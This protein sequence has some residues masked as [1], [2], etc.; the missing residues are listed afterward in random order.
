MVTIDVSLRASAGYPKEFQF[1][2]DWYRETYQLAPSL[3]GDEVERYFW[4]KG[5]PK[6]HNLSPYFNPLFV[7]MQLRALG[8]EI[9]AKEDPRDAYLENASELDPHPLLPR[10]PTCLSA[11]HRLSK[12]SDTEWYNKSVFI[13]RM[14][15]NQTTRHSLFFDPSFMVDAEG[16]PMERPLETY[17]RFHAQGDMKV[18]TL[19]DPEFYRSA[20]PDVARAIEGGEHMSQNLLEHFIAFGMREN[21]LPF[22]D[23]DLDYYASQ[24]PDVASG[25]SESGISLV[26]HFL[27]FGLSEHRDPNP[28]FKTQYYIEAQPHV[29]EE[30]RRLRLVGPFEHFLKIGYKAGL[31]ASQP[32]YSVELPEHMGKVMYEKSAIRLRES[33]CET[34]RRSLFRPLRMRRRSPASSQW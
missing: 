13:L 34:M 14:L 30:I 16:K 27:N 21:R 32:L 8:I 18:S 26:Y 9:D 15:D 4:Q 31:K 1:D 20:Y 11:D 5:S 12:V 10:N 22:P 23:L 28:Y 2:R 19:F 24:N 29:L 3:R 33:S 17:L 6:G 7:G 25:V